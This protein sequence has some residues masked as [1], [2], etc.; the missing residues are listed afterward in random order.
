MKVLSGETFCFLIG[1]VQIGAMLGTRLSHKRETFVF[2]EYLCERL[3][4]ITKTR[5]FNKQIVEFHIQ[6][7]V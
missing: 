3:S 2:I 4:K 1:P 6:I 7:Y 5:K